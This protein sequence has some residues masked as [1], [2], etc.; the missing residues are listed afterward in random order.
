MLTIIRGPSGT[1][2]S[3]IARHLDGIEQDNWFEAD[4]F[5]VRN[6][7]YEF[8]AK[9]LGQAHK[10]CQDN[11]RKLLESGSNAIVS[12]TTITSQEL[13]AYLE[14]AKATKVKIIR[15]PGP[16]NIS[17]LRNRNIHC[18]PSKSLERMI[19]RYEPHP[20]EKE[21]EDLSVFSK[22]VKA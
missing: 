21:W 5:F 9:R 18:V 14:I 11:I 2:K 3:T 12:N 20:E 19:N 10:W 4:M 22:K 8:D 16:W 1:G 17:D 7:H 15:T 13:D 6:G